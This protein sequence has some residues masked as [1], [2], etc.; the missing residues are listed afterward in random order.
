MA[1]VEQQKGEAGI[2]EEK[3][4]KGPGQVHLHIWGVEVGCDPYLTP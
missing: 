1:K 2:L 4:K 3:K